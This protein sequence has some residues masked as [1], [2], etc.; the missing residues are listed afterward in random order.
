VHRLLGER[1]AHA[2][3]A[4]EPDHPLHLFS[5]LAQRAGPACLLTS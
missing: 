2:P 1:A 5:E 3:L 4:H